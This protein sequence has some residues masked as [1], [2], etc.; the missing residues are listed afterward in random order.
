MSHPSLSL[1]RDQRGTVNVESVKNKRVGDFVWIIV[2]CIHVE[3]VSLDVE[4]EPDSTGFDQ[5]GVREAKNKSA[6]KF[7][8]NK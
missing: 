6:L 5:E 7:T 3:T 4:P 8:T 1:E 2:Q